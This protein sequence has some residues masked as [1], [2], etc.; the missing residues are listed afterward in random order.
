MPD[1]LQLTSLLKPSFYLQLNS[2]SNL[3]ISSYVRYVAT[4]E[5]DGNDPKWFNLASQSGHHP[6]GS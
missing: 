3:Q 4:L 5:M 1:L 6:Y 2:F